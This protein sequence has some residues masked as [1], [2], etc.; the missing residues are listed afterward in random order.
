MLHLFHT[1]TLMKLPEIFSLL[2]SFKS[3]NQKAS[4]GSFCSADP[5]RIWLDYSATVPTVSDILPAPTGSRPE[6]SLFPFSSLCLPTLFYFPFPA[7]FHFTLTHSSHNYLVFVIFFTI[8]LLIYYTL[9]QSPSI[10][11][12]YH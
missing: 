2:Y 11:L 1:K 4:W 9:F 12:S 10:F 7:V 3:E 6:G 5:L 8:S